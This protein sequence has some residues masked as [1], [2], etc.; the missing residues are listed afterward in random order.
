[1]TAGAFSLGVAAEV[2]N[3]VAAWLNEHRNI[4]ACVWTGLASN[5]KEQKTDFSVANVIRYLRGLPDPA[6]ARDI[7]TRQHR[8]RPEYAL[9]SVSS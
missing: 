6:G 9:L 4:Q 3:P 2:H 8:F 5:W 7:Q 1:M